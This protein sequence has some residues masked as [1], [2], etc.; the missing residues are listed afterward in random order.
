VSCVDASAWVPAPTAAGIAQALNTQTPNV[1][2]VL[3]ALTEAAQ[4][5]KGWR[6]DALS[7]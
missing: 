3:D 4:H 6:Q 7:V 1:L 5:E 2:T